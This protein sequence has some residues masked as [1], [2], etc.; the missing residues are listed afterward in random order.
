MAKKRI[1]LLPQEMRPHREY[2]M[3]LIPI[4]LYVIFVLYAGASGLWNH[5]H[6]KKNDAQ[7]VY[8]REQN[9]Q[10][11]R[12]I[13][14]LNDRSRRFEEN[15]HAVVALRKVLNRKNYWSEIFKELSILIPKGVWLTSFTNSAKSSQLVLRG[16][17]SSQEV[18]AQFLRILETSEHFSEARMISAEKQSE[19]QPTRYEFEFVIPV[20]AATGGGT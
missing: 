4:V 18:I 3:E 15:N 6:L 10:L 8:L 1:N 19:V 7:L 16:E 20:K 14:S 2:P 17:S 11:N 12:E 9:K 5:H 13:Q